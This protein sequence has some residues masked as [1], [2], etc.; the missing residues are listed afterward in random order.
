MKIPEPLLMSH[1]ALVESDECLVCSGYSYCV[2]DGRYEYYFFTGYSEEICLGE[3][4]VL[5]KL[6][7][8]AALVKA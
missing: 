5:R 8:G 7:E 6:Q 3:E 1:D 2:R 4:E